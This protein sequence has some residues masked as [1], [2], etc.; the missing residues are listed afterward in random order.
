MAELKSIG[1]IFHKDIRVLLSQ[2][3]PLTL[4]IAPLAITPLVVFLLLFKIKCIERGGKKPTRDMVERAPH[5]GDLPHYLT[6]D[7]PSVLSKPQV[8]H[9]VAWPLRFF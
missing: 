9:R 1:L 2:G 5:S 7:M 4:T 3:E 8:S 6:L